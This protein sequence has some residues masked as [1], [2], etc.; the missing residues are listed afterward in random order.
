MV[1]EMVR[2]NNSMGKE[3]NANSAGRSIL[4]QLQMSSRSHSSFAVSEEDSVFVFGSTTS[5]KYYFYRI[6]MF[7]SDID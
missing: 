3:F 1:F 5:V 2:Y 7:V 6:A 4:Y